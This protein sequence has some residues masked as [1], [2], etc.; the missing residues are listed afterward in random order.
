MFTRG[1]IIIVNL[2]CSYFEERKV[3]ARGGKGVRDGMRLN[4][5]CEC[6]LVCLLATER[7]QLNVITLYIKIRKN[8]LT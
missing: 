6:S 5:D 4:V 2:R 3:R 1:V 8:V 7:I